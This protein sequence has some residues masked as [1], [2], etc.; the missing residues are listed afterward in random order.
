MEEGRPLQ[1]LVLAQLDIYW[2]EGREKEK[3]NESQPK[4]HI[5]HE[6]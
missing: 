3:K 5:L 4:S 6:N 2:G 1:Q